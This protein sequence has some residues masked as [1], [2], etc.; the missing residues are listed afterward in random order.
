M[1]G[2]DRRAQM[3]DFMEAEFG[4]EGPYG[5]SLHQNWDATLGIPIAPTP[6]QGAPI[7]SLKLISAS[8][9]TSTMARPCWVC[10]GPIGE[11]EKYDDRRY[12]GEDAPVVVRL[13]MECGEGE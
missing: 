9:R 11:G 12:Q 7:P 2:R 8:R 6:P 10:G 3:F 4:P 13:H 1:N 5:G